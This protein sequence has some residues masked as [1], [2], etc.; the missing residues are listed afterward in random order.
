MIFLLAPGTPAPPLGEEPA[1][2]PGT[3]VVKGIVESLGMQIYNDILQ[4]IKEETGQ[5]VYAKAKTDGPDPD[6]HSVHESS[7]RN[8]WYNIFEGALTAEVTAKAPNNQDDGTE[9]PYSPGG[10]HTALVKI[11]YNYFSDDDKKG[12][13]PNP[14]YPKNASEQQKRGVY[15]WVEAQQDDDPYGMTGQFTHAAACAAF[16]NDGKVKNFKYAGNVT[17]Y[18]GGGKVKA[19]VKTQQ[20][21]DG[22]DPPYVLEQGAVYLVSADRFQFKDLGGGQVQ[23]SPPPG[24][25]TV[26]LLH[27]YLQRGSEPYVFPLQR[28]YDPIV[29]DLLLDAYQYRVDGTKWRLS[30]GQADLTIVGA[31]LEMGEWSIPRRGRTDEQLLVAYFESEAVRIV[32]PEHAQIHYRPEVTFRRAVQDGADLSAEFRQPMILPGPESPD[33]RS[34]RENLQGVA[35]GV[36]GDVDAAVQLGVNTDGHFVR[37]LFEQSWD[38]TSEEVRFLVPDLEYH[39]EYPATFSDIEE[40]SPEDKPGGDLPPTILDQLAFTPRGT[41][42]TTGP[43][44]E[45]TIANPTDTP[46]ELTIGPFVVPSTGKY[47]GYVVPDEQLIS[48]GAH[49]EATYLLTSYCTNIRRKPVPDGLAVVPYDN[50]ITPD[51]AQPISYH[52][53]AK[54]HPGMEWRSIPAADLDERTVLLSFPGADLPIAYTIDFDHYPEAAAS[55]LF[56]GIDRISEAYDELKDEGLISTPFSTDPAKEREAV[57]QQS[58]WRFTSA[59]NGEEYK[60]DDFEENLIGDFERKSGQKFRTA[61]EPVREEL[62]GGVDQFWTTFTAVGEEAKVLTTPANAK[63][64]GNN[65]QQRYRN[66][67]DAVRAD[68]GD[69]DEDALAELV[70]FLGLDALDQLLPEFGDMGLGSALGAALTLANMP[71]EVCNM[72]RRLR[73]AVNA[74]NGAERTA[75]CSEYIRS[76]KSVAGLPSISSVQEGTRELA[77]AI[78]GMT[79]AQRR[80]AVG[81]LN[82]AIRLR[83]SP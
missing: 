59:L 75:A 1:E 83:C 17:V 61:P 73:D 3:G 20:V 22:E 30:E 37:D 81:A 26:D 65:E 35:F 39:T 63:Q 48:V 40:P 51:E 64:N 16:A 34:K 4:A 76:W 33:G 44:I 50:W 28:G 31:A 7:D 67:R 79:R 5:I 42:L 66:L 80:E 77:E 52:E 82:R 36:R 43:A 53:F 69:I 71:S 57:I 24:A 46:V 29:Q 13:C 47:Q 6:D 11:S 49:E 14:I 54:E 18:R 58:F 38:G 9:Q 27:S 68:D 62:T 25:S 12:W 19:E 72:L 55:F 8:N 2:V 74:R 78:E 60:V 45:L 41:G 70:T 23:I 10:P 32:A 21:A 56:E 15:G